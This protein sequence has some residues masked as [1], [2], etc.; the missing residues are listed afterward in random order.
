MSKV[1][2]VVMTESKEGF[3]VNEYDNN[4]ERI[5]NGDEP[6]G[7]IILQQTAKIN[8]GQWLRKQKRSCL[9]RGNLEDLEE[10]MDEYPKLEL[11]G[12]LVVTEVLEK[13]L[14]PQQ[15]K[16]YLGRD[17]FDDEEL[18]EERA[19]NYIK[20]AGKDGVVLTAE[21]ERIFR[22]V[23]YDD[24]GLESDQLIQHDNTD[25]VDK[26]NRVERMKKDR[27]KIQ[28]AKLK[29]QSAGAGA[30]DLDGMSDEEILEH[31]DADEADDN[32]ADDDAPAMSAAG[33]D[34]DASGASLPENELETAPAEDE[35]ELAIRTSKAVANK[36]AADKNS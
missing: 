34:D 10:L 13:D 31:A 35:N 6:L 3:I 2:K 18:Y 24:T 27:I 16:K 23:D 7:Y 25:D 22:F 14:T 8:D 26:Q 1:S 32:D 30:D 5:E 33:S 11:P 4:E 19:G 20:T 21:G 15:Q 36:K 29:L 28:R 12:R 17:S 9:L